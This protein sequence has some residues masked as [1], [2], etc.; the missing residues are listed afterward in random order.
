MNMKRFAKKKDPG[1]CPDPS[2]EFVY[3]KAFC[4]TLHDRILEVS[5]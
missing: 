3:E 1:V 4:F 2:R 5:L